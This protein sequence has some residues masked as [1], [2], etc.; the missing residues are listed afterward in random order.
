[1]AITE[2]NPSVL[3]QSFPGGL[4]DPGHGVV[5]TVLFIV[6]DQ[7]RSREFYQRVMGG[8]VVRERNPVMVRL[9]NIWVILN[10]GGP[11]TADKP[12]IT[13]APHSDP[14]ILS[15]ALNLRVS[16]FDAALAEYEARGAKLLAPPADWPIERRCYLT[17]PDGYIIE[18]GEFTNLTP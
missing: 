15:V 6:K 9:H 11:P 16:N 12:T 7:D 17:D 18:I 14:S 2:H 8:Q 3:D 10:N 5:V 13:C 4:P 1:M